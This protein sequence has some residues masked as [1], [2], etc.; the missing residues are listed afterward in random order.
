MADSDSAHTVARIGATIAGEGD[1]MPKGA[2]RRAVGADQWMSMWGGLS[3]VDASGILSDD[4]RGAK[5][6]LTWIGK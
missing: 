1:S 3:G 2:C 6:R 5:Q 4:T